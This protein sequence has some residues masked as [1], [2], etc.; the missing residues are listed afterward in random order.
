M[1]DR[2]DGH[3]NFQQRVEPFVHDNRINE[4]GDS[5][6]AALF[7]G[8][9][10]AMGLNLVPWPYT[11]EEKANWAPGTYTEVGASLR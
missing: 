11:A 9:I 7:G 10:R 6:E 8:S 4:V 2:S 1:Q 5:W 3:G